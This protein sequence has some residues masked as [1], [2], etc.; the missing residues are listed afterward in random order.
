[1]GT[2]PGFFQLV[3][4]TILKIVGGGLITGRAK[5]HWRN[6]RGDRALRVRLGGRQGIVT[7]DMWHLNHDRGG[8]DIQR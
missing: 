3:N 7:K 5:D 2:A 4:V 1:M 8:P 6:T